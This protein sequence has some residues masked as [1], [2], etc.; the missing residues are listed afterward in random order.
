M[1][2]IPLAALLALVFPSTALAGPWVPDLGHGYA[3]LNLRY[4]YGY[5]YHADDGSSIAFRDYHE[6]FVGSYGEIGIGGGVALTLHSDL[7]RTFTLRDPNTG[8]RRAHVAPGDPALGLRVRLL[9]RGRFVMAAEGSVR[10][11]LASDRVV[12]TAYGSKG[13]HPVIG[14]LRVGPGVFDLFG[15]LSMGY[16]WNR[17]YL[18]GGVGYVG[19][20]GGYRDALHATLESGGRVGRDRRWALRGRV[21]AHPR[22]GSRTGGAAITESPS[23]QGNGT[24]YVGFAFEFDRRFGE[25]LYVGGALQGGFGMVRQQV[26]GPVLDGYVA[27]SF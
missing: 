3:K 18:A 13:A 2:L 23:G 8:R 20:F 12:D 6:A 17:A 14:E 15:G 4:L 26:G 24:R 25:H 5:G 19:R 9:R 22:F 16:G 11:P 1:R 10:A 27:A 21:T 7:V